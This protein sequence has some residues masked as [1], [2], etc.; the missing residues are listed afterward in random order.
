MKSF[1]WDADFCARKKVNYYD[2]YYCSSCYSFVK[3]GKKSLNSVATQ[4]KE[5]IVHPYLYRRK[6]FLW[7]DAAA[8]SEIRKTEG[9]RGGG[10]KRHLIKRRGKEGTRN[11]R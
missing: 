10:E 1:F 6:C 9:G 5:A 7:R 4:E 11:R 8:A 2:Y 3:P